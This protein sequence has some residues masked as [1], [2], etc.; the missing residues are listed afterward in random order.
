MKDLM[1]WSAAFL[2][3]VLIVFSS[4]L[5]SQEV[6]ENLGV[7]V[8]VIDA[9]HGGKDGGCVGSHALEKNIAL[10]IALKT[11]KYIEE[12]IK[13]V[14]VIYTRTTDVFIELH[15][16][17][18]IANRAKA[19]LFISIHV[20]GFT[21]ATPKGTSSYVMGLAK[22]ESN[23]R[24]AM[25][26]NEAIL[27]ED[28]YEEKYENFDP[29][30][31]ES[32]IAMSLQQSAFLNQSLEI[33]ARIQDQFRERVGRVDRGVKQG[34]FLVLNQTT[35]PSVLVETGFISHPED[36]KF[37]ATD[38]GQE[39]M[40]SAIYRAFKDYKQSI[41]EKLLSSFQMAD[42]LKKQQQNSQKKGIEGLVFKVQLATSASKIDL[43]PGNF[44]GL[45]DVEVYEAGGLF[46]YTYG[47]KATAEEAIVAQEEARAAGYK[48]AFIVAFL[49]GSR[50]S[51][52]EANKLLSE[53]L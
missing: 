41:E 46:R 23:L 36:Q 25:R 44:K 39:Y 34:P 7:K 35:M 13:D 3:S 15:E 14:K 9:G 51:V 10:A 22:S 48:D 6:T 11:G 53:A 45:K 49:N 42:D 24:A 4:S 50:I 21:N 52:G 27:L 28:N 19:D 47:Q 30:S 29:N 43:V 18:K 16:R 40:A 12:N 1:K 5:K 17:A 38:E 37:L 32:Y 8:V 31:P 2:C 26:E 33:A 20:D